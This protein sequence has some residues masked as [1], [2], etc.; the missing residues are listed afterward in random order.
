MTVLLIFSLDAVSQH[1]II[2]QGG[3]RLKQLGGKMTGGANTDSLKRRD[4]NEDSITVRFR[5]LD[6]TLNY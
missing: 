1:N 3:G 2:Q 6:S 5:Y 4:K